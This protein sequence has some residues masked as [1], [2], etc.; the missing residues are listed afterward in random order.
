MRNPKLYICLLC[1]VVVLGG[2]TTTKSKTADN[3][4]RIA[5]ALSSAADEAASG[6]MMQQSLSFQERIYKKDPKDPTAIVNYARALRKVGRVDDARL[7]VQ[8]AAQAR[9]APIEV[10]T[11]YAMVLVASG[12]FNAALGA[13]QSATEK[14]KKSAPAIHAL[15]L[16]LAGLGQYEDAQLQFQQALRIWPEDQDK[17]PIINNLAM[18]L[19][20]QGKIAEA[21][22]VMALAS[23]EALD[24][25][26]YQNNRALLQSLD[27]R[28][29]ERAA[30]S[31]A[32]GGDALS[33]KKQKGK[34][35]RAINPKG[36]MA[37]ILE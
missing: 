30:I 15:A 37:P 35:T 18:C 22:S 16:A 27:D 33:G 13:A 32:H 36:K 5:Q 31:P 26:V 34:A 10:L 21:R 6:G 28:G 19:A 2:C 29:V 1:S 8:S 17:T 9:R 24:S 23:G 4:M 11:E 14:S 3:D 7:V 25:A 20:A 12:D